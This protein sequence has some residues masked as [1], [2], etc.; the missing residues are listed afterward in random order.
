MVYSTRQFI[1]CLT[2]C[3]FILVFFSLF[4]IAI[5]LLREERAN[6]SAFR[7]FV[8]FALVLVLSVSFSS[9][10]LGR[11]AV[12]DCGTPW[13]CLLPFFLLAFLHNKPFQKKDL[14]QKAAILFSFRVDHFF[15]RKGSKTV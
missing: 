8:Q 4:S 5:T 2:L 15:G 11:V 6:I 14:F 1:L 7:M 10:C 12:C 9:W 13:T 3:Y